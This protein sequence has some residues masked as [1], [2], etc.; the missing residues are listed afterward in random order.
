MKTEE[1][2][3][4]K[5]VHHGH[6]IKRARMEKQIKQEALCSMVD[7][8]QSAISKYESMRVVDDK[9]LE[10]FAKAIGVP[11]EDLKTIEEEA[12]MVVFENNTNTN[13]IE[14][15]NNGSIGAGCYENATTI[16]NP[17]DQINNLFERLLKE[18]DARITILEQQVHDLKQE[19]RK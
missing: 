1:L 7:L 13:N 6:N 9:I 2:Q 19:L 3:V 12:P 17:I 5:I 14:T 4:N 18:K 11:V 10:K 16:N 15:N 8:T